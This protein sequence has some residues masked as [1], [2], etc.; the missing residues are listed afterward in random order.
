MD[1]TVV[2]K[3]KSMEIESVKLVSFFSV[4]PSSSIITLSPH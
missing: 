2:A 3:K 1:L 4:H